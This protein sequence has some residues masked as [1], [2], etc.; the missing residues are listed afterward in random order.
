MS[1]QAKPIKSSFLKQL[2]EFLEPGET[3]TFD[4][5]G[6]RIEFVP[7]GESPDRALGR[8]QLAEAIR[9]RAPFPHHSLN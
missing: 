7:R 1:I 3:A 2:A 8:E 5:D 4:V 9:C 6:T